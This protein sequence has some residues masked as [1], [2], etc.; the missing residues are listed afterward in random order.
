[1]AKLTQDDSLHLF[2]QVKTVMKPYE[3]V[4]IKARFDIEGRYDLWSMKDLVN[5]P[6][7]KADGSGFRSADRAEHIGFYFMPVYT[8]EAMKETIHPNLLALLKGKACFHIKSTS[9]ELLK[10]IGDALKKGFEAYKKMG[11]AV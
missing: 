5:P 2:N 6:G 9:P 3:R 8:T 1:M 10:Q 7:K 4:T 11:W